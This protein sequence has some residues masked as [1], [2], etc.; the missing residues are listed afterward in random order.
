MLVYMDI[1]LK[2]HCAIT[3]DGSS[4]LQLGSH[5]QQGLWYLVCLSVC[6]SNAHFSD[7]VR[8]QWLLV[9]HGTEYFAIEAS[10]KSYGIVCLP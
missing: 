5:V 9:R 4:G 10:F 3:E 2:T 1:F 8:Y 7:T 6:L